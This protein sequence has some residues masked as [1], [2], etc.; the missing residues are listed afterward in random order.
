MVDK[1][2]EKADFLN[3][4]KGIE[5]QED[6]TEKDNSKPKKPITVYEDEEPE[7]VESE[8]KK[9]IAKVYL[10]IAVPHSKGPVISVKAYPYPPKPEKPSFHMEL[11]ETDKKIKKSLLDSGYMNRTSDDNPFPSGGWRMQYALAKAKKKSK[12]S[13]PH[14]ILEHYRWA[15]RMV[16]YIKPEL[17][18]I[19]EFEKGRKKRYYDYQ[20]FWTDNHKVLRNKAIRQSLEPLRMRPLPRDPNKF[21]RNFGGVFPSGQW[22]IKIKYKVKGLSYHWIFALDL[23]DKDQIVLLA[24]E[25]NAIQISGG[26]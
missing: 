11:P 23:K 15:N 1:P 16:K 4:L 19:N 17:L 22:W 20:N 21:G 12:I 10:T 8:N 6:K 2:K 13:S 7:E 25:A 9:G 5:A 18:K 3:K 24:N 14:S 26:W